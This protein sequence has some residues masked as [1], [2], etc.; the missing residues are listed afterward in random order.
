MIPVTREV[1]VLKSNTPTVKF[2]MEVS[3]RNMHLLI[4]L[5]R[6]SLY[7]NKKLAPLREYS[8][9]A[10]DAHIEAG[11]PKRPILVSLP[12]VLEPELKIRDFG[13]GLNIIE[14]AETYF[15]YLESTKRE[16]NDLNGMLGLGSKSAFAYSD[17]FVVTS[18]NNGKKHIVT[19][20]ISGEPTLDYEGSTD[21]ESGIEIAIPVKR[22]DISAFVENALN[23]YKYWPV[24]PII[25]G[26]TQ[27]KLDEYFKPIDAKAIFCDEKWTIRPAGYD[28][29]E[30]VC[31]M[32]NVPY[33]INWDQVKS[34]LRGERATKLA[35]IWSFLESNIVELRLDIGSIDF[36][37]NR[38]ALQYT[39]HALEGIAKVLCEIY[40]RIFDLITEKI[41]KAKNLWDAMIVYNQLFHGNRVGSD[42]E[43]DALFS[44]DMS[45]IKNMLQNSLKWNGIVINNGQFEDLEHWDENLGYIDSNHNSWRHRRGAANPIFFTYS[46]GEAQGKKVCCKRPRRWHDCHIIPSTQSVVVV[47]DLEKTS[48]IGAAA[49]YLLWEKYPDLHHVYFLRLGDKKIRKAFYEKYNFDSVPVIYVS[50]IQ[51]EVKA[52]SKK[53]RITYTGSHFPRAP[54]MMPYVDM[55]DL[56]GHSHYRHDIDWRRETVKVHD[57]TGGVF[58]IYDRGSIEMGGKTYTSS[59]ATQIISAYADYLKFTGKK[60]VKLYGI[61]RRTVNAKWFLDEIRCNNWI[62]LDKA[63]AN[64]MANVD[65]EEVKRADVFM[66]LTSDN[67]SG[68]IGTHTAKKLLPLVDSKSIVS[69]YCKQITNGVLKFKILRGVAKVFGIDGFTATKDEV[70]NSSLKALIKEIRRRY[71]MIFRLSNNS[72]IQ[73][74]G[75]NDYYKLDTSE[76]TDIA[77]YINAIDLMTTLEKK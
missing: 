57:I 25:N 47:H 48:C 29:D 11:I 45:A 31:V 13:K 10:Y 56:I 9:N 15:K 8:T 76:T 5:L 64:C 36:T 16:S 39:D 58:V 2:K 43:K 46:R 41:S 1:E 74:C 21:E 4:P 54:I 34:L 18:I 61:H 26:V 7:S 63:M 68:Y 40:D 32:G 22:D 62:P 42:T 20:P 44:G 14:M 35:N 67:G 50:D 55:D 69:D 66:T 19:C 28:K 27:Y 38:E 77:N 49:R 59:N 3:Q 53:N 33:P 23:F 30:A 71:P 73:N 52:F 75:E 17:M 60:G 6:D 51:D 70:N 12:T 37:P 24:R 65:K 72:A